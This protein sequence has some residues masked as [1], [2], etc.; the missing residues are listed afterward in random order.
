[1]ALVSTNVSLCVCRQPTPWFVLSVLLS[2]S[3]V[4]LLHR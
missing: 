3:L 2:L 1:M 4:L